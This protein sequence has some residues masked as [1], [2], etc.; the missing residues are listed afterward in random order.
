MNQ[1]EHQEPRALRSLRP[2]VGDD[3][4]AVVHRCLAK[5]PDARFA[6]AR[7]L[8]EA[9]APFAKR[10]AAAGDGKTKRVVW[11][12]AIAVAAIAVVAI[13]IASMRASEPAPAPA[14]MAPAPSPSPSPT[15][16]PVPSP[17]LAP[18]SAPA[19]APASS[20]TAAPSIRKQVAPRRP[21][22]PRTLEDDD[23]IE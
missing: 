19:P 20:P 21:A 2:E 4:A 10:A 3:L 1:I 16:A 18:P 15:P 14:A 22:K 23:R 17:A 13:A 7:A 6:D 5:D 12:S 9:L 8:A 11:G